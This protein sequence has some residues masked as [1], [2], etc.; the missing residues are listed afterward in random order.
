MI[1]ELEVMSTGDYCKNEIGD[2][3]NK[4]IRALNTMEAANTSTN[5]ARDEICSRHEWYQ[6][7]CIHCR[8]QAVS[9]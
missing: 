6:G 8:K 3:V 5:N 9:H 1:N 4:I 7:E 2:A